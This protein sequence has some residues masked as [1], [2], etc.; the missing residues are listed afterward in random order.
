MIKNDL[1]NELVSKL[2]VDELN[3]LSED[4]ILSIVMERPGHPGQFGFMLNLPYFKS[5]EHLSETMNI[6]LSKLGKINN[7]EEKYNKKKTNNRVV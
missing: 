4:D 2:S 1:L 5:K 3:N 7:L 6:L